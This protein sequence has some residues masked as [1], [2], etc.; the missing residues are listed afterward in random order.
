MMGAANMG[1]LASLYGNMQSNQQPNAA[2]PTSP[3]PQ[4]FPQKNATPTM[5]AANMGGLAGIMG[6]PSREQLQA[7]GG[8]VANLLGP[9]DRPLN[10]Q[11]SQPIQ[12]YV[13]M[14]GRINPN[15]TFRPK[16]PSLGTPPPPGQDRVFTSMGGGLGSVDPDTGA[17]TRPNTPSF[18]PQRMPF[19]GLG[20]F[21]PYSGMG[22]MGGFNPYGGMGGFNPYG[23]RGG[24]NIFGGGFGGMGGFNPYGGMGGFNPYGGMGGFNP[25]SGMGGMGNMGG[26]N[27]YGGSGRANM[28][29]GLGGFMPYNAP[30]PRSLPLPQSNITPMV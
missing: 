18:Q 3:Q 20:G 19:Y 7:T 2:S 23:G 27:P 26:F 13:T 6:K 16:D 17:I 14:G 11:M 12:Q 1:G 29:G 4:P 30:K 8:Q 25:Y 21:S 15:S 5:G 22:G 10:R 28:L 9:N 24:Y